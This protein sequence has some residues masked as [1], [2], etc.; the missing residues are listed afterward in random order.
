MAS[1]SFMGSPGNIFSEELHHGRTFE[2]PPFL[3]LIYILAKGSTVS[4]CFKKKLDK[5]FFPDNNRAEKEPVK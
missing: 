5:L 3:L 2:A 1:R 4:N